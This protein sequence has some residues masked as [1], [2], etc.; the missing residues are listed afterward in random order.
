[1]KTSHLLL[2]GFATLSLTACQTFDGFK[3]D[4][5]TAGSAISAKVGSLKTADG[6]IDPE[7]ESRTAT[8]ATGVTN[9]DSTNDNKAN[10]VVNNDAC[11]PLYVDPQLS[12]ASEFYNPEKPSQGTEVSSLDLT[13]T[14]S[15]CN[16]D[17][18]YK[19]VKIQLSFKGTLGPKA[20]RKDNDRPFFA[21]P[22]F[23]SVADKDGEEL[24]KELFA[25]SVTYETEQDSIELYETI[26]QR[27]PLNDDGSDPGYQIK[28]GF[29]LT[30][31]Q[32]FY[33]ASR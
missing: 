11:P 25:A 27:L 6:N 28:I 24:A 17:D 26:R 21:Y 7:T 20:K 9:A 13:N 19:E 15:E 23:V 33:N 18:G 4:L 10:V 2:I 32:L 1:M 12:H 22:Y 8:A 30:E 14:A 31:D 5:S 3:Q 29:Q 16:V